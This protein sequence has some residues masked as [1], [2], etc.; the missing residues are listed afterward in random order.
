MN[1][2]QGIKDVSHAEHES[3]FYFEILLKVFL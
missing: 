2:E 3:F 1:N